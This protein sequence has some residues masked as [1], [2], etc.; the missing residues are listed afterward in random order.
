MHL[1]CSIKRLNESI[2]F[3]DW[4]TTSFR[5]GNM[6][7]I[8]DWRWV[9]GVVEEMAM[10]SPPN[11]LSLSSN[12][13]WSMPCNFGQR[14][15]YLSQLFFLLFFQFEFCYE[16]N[17]ILAIGFSSN[18]FGFI[19][20]AKL[21]FQSLMKKVGA[22]PFTRPL[23]RESRTYLLRWIYCLYITLWTI[24]GSCIHVTCYLCHWPP[25]AT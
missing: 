4:L 11:Y 14:K 19:I 8:K 24:I 10:Q 2:N 9:I 15:C 5:F 22:C 13:F 17:L 18:F 1:R 7:F 16:L 12:C 6:C 21:K 23:L 20:V 25:P 3:F